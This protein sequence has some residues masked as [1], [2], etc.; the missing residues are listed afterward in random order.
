MSRPSKRNRLLIIFSALPPL[1]SLSY[2]FITLLLVS[3]PGNKLSVPLANRTN[4]SCINTVCVFIDLLKSFIWNYKKTFTLSTLVWSQLDAEYCFNNFNMCTMNT[5]LRWEVKECA[6]GVNCELRDVWALSDWRTQK[7]RKK[8]LFFLFFLSRLHNMFEVSHSIIYK[9]NKWSDFGLFQYFRGSL[10]ELEHFQLNKLKLISWFPVTDFFL[11]TD[12]AADHV[13]CPLVFSTVF[14]Q[15]VRVCQENSTWIHIFSAS[16]S[17]SSSSTE[18]VLYIH[19]STF[20]QYTHM[21]V[22]RV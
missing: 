4:W 10:F 16:A 20:N 22:Q 5:W 8:F 1:S 11:A 6:E 18:Q 12:D 14:S 7:E 2:I 3:L 19:S 13:T 17:S 9:L 21:C 15:T